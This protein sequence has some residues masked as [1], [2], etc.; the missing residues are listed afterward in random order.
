MNLRKRT[1]RLAVLGM[2]GALVL[3]ACGGG[4]DDPPKADSGSGK[5]DIVVWAHQ[6]SEADAIKAAVDSFNSSQSDVTA[7]LE[8][9]PEADYTKTVTS[10]PIADLPDVLE[11][12]GPL[13]SS[14]VYDTR[15]SPIDGLV[16]DDTVAN[17]LDSVK[18]QNTYS[19]DK[20]YGISQFDSGLAL[21]GN[22]KLLKGV[23]YP[24]TWDQAWTAEQFGGLLET[25]AGKD[26]DGKVLDIKQNYGG[27]WPTYGF[28]PIVSSAGGQVLTDGK[29]SGS[30]DSDAVVTAMKTFG[31]WADYVDPNT[32]DNSFVKGKVALSWVG[33][34]QYTG[35]KEALG[36]DLVVIPLPDFGSGA[37]SGQG[38]WAWG[39]S[40]STE[41]G[42]AA[43]KLLDYLAAD[44]AV[45]AV[46]T[47]NGA[48]PGT[49]SAL[50]AS[51]LY[52]AGG[53]LELYA[54]QLK[55]TCGTDAPSADCVTVPRPLTAGYPVISAEFSK[56]VF[57]VL[58]GGDPAAELAKAAKE[59]DSN[60]AD[61][62][63]YE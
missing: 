35:Y 13:M 62:N 29:A 40:S 59:I 1:P 55:A 49:T 23:E 4:T 7:K 14:F 20:L 17:Q 15:L 8:L 44:D 47:V 37:K 34:W 2:A 16:S 63:N 21:Y 50:E 33:H 61:A 19:D 31:S 30:L 39:I 10:T 11:Y 22:K 28:L 26:A 42:S 12:D 24:T 56:A 3:S 58:K 53:P 60:F 32:D 45:G 25:L 48:P 36:D 5:G 46:T 27:E 52:K 6:G 18:T 9:K 43:G 38:S 57:E 54:E 41:N 51:E